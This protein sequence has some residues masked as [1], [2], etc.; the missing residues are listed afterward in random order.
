MELVD[1]NKIKAIIFDF[2][3]VIV[4]SLDI[5]TGAFKKLYEVF[6][7][8]IATKVVNHHLINGGISRY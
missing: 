7:E 5:K 4:E 3:G 8:E 1:K 6:S 2:D